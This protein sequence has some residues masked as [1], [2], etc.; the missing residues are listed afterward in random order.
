MTDQLTLWHARVRNT[1]P[2]T[3]TEAA[4]SQ[5]EINI[6]G[7]RAALLDLMRELGEATDEEIATAY[8][9]LLERELVPQHTPSGLRHRR[10]ELLKKGML[11]DTGEKR[12][13]VSGR[14]ARVWAFVA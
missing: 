10:D 6:T 3:S 2:D 7:A 1:D 8:A 13:N 14:R 11:R 12:L 9:W 5:R 4:Q